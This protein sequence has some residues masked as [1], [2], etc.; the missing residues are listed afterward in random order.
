MLQK[1]FSLYTSV[2]FE[3]QLDDDD[4]PQDIYQYITTI[5]YSNERRRQIIFL[6][7]SSAPLSVCYITNK[8]SSLLLV[9]T[10]VGR[11]AYC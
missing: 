4:K 2:W 9:F 11:P 1:I 8:T 6:A 3:T 10:A 7:A 5:T